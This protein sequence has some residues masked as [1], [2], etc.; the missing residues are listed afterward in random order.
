MTL[1]TGNTRP[2]PDG[3]PRAHEAFTRRAAAAAE[4]AARPVRRRGSN[5]EE[6]TYAAAQPTSF[7]KGLKHDPYGIVCRA[8]YETFVAALTRPDWTMSVPKPET[9]SN[10][11]PTRKWESPLAGHYY[12][13]QGPDMGAEAMDPAPQ[14]GGSELTAEIAT[15]YAMALL[16]DVPLADF[17][18]GNGP[19]GCFFPAGHP[20]A[21]E[22]ASVNDIVA[23]LRKLSWHDPGQQPA[24]LGAHES[25]RRK[26]LWESDSAGLTLQ[27]LFRGSS[28]GCKSG[29]LMSQ[30]LL[31]GSSDI[32][33][34]R[35]GGH[36]PRLPCEGRI[37]FGAQIID[38][39]VAFNTP[40]QD[41]M[42]D[43]PSWLDVQN[44][45][46]LRSDICW[47]DGR[48]FIATPRDL[49]TYV[50]YDQLYQAYLNA[51][52]ILL[53]ADWPNKVTPGNPIAHSRAATSTGFATWG[54]P[55]ILSLVTEV[56]SRALRAVRRQKFQVHRRGRP[57]VL[58]AR[59]TQVANG[60]TGSM[61]AAAV[62]ALQR[63]LDEMGAGDPTD[64]TKPGVLLHWIAE[65]NESLNDNRP[66]GT[67]AVPIDPAK[68]YLLPMAFPEG[69]P[70]HP[71]Y[72]AG[73][74][75]VAGACVTILKA[76]F[77]S[78][79]KM[80]EIAGYE[81]FF[82]P[83]TSGG[84]LSSVAPLRDTTIA[85]ELNKLAAN[86]AIAR[87]MAGVHYYTDYYDSVRLGERI[88]VGILEEQLIC[89]PEPVT[90]DFEGFDG[91]RIRL[92][93]DGSGRSRSGL[94]VAV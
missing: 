46:D 22:A 73:H 77:R 69:S 45:C 81:C 26:A 23:E 36:I 57:E 44:G 35:P 30:F 66:A 48:R 63:M 10:G 60:A 53:E 29:P 52:L 68:N 71:A 27:S 86:I 11:K 85:H 6:I 9:G 24:G 75:T 74:A 40:G 59:L 87:N 82:V 4:L 58:A 55:H 28:P 61:D 13:N 39:R 7:T 50:H 14:L 80:T 89:C 49:A 1:D 12:D 84:A 62:T 3:L 79:A 21:G 90:L 93:T 43:W 78:D 42:T 33:G 72:G 34:K 38:Q 16:R 70:M 31:V 92:T 17:V 94:G 19:G 20:R 64:T 37:N 91:H 32:G 83:D 76:F 18:E 54:G 56:A 47:E 88:A 2:R 25:R 51:C 8:T 5:G 67:E 41:F 15:L 65:R